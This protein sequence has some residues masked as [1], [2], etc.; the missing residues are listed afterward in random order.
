M[1]HRPLP[2]P[3][4]VPGSTRLIKR[5]EVCLRLQISR[6]TLSR[7]MKSDPGFPQARRLGTSVRWV[8]AEVEAY[9][10]GLRRVEYPDHA[11]DPNAPG[12]DEDEA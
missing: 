3:G 2:G 9:I 7:R 10:A 8:E 6:A 11:F 4:Y 12:A 1:L 5:D